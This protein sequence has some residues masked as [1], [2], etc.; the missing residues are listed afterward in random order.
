LREVGFFIAILATVAALVY[1]PHV[2]NG[3]LYY[4]DWSHASDYHDEG[5][6]S[7]ATQLW[8]H[9]IP[10]RP[11][12]AV[13]LPTPYAL[14]GSS[15][16]LHLAM[17]LVLGVAASTCFY[18]F[19]R[20]LSL[21]SVPAGA[22]ALLSLL[23]PWSEAA[24]LWPTASINN[25]AV[26]AYL[27]G[28]VVALR[29]LRLRGKRAVLVHGTAIAMYLVSVLIYEV[30]A[31]AIVFSGLLYRTRTSLTRAA[32]RWL[33]DAVL[34]LSA[35]GISAVYTARVRHVGSLAD[36]VADVPRFSRQGVS[37]LGRSFLPDALDSAP[38][39][40]VVVVAI[41]GLF[42]YAF[43]VSR[44]ATRH[45]LRR[46]LRIAAVGAGAIASAYVMFLGSTIYPL[47][48]GVDTRVN[49]FAGF[50]FASFSY[51]TVVIAA[52]LLPLRGAEALAVVALAGF[53][54][55]LGFV[56]RLRADIGRWDTAR[57]MQDDFLSALE[58][59]LP[60]PTRGS[61]IY[62]FGY[63]AEV[64]PGIPIFTHPWDLNGA[65]RLTYHDPTLFGLPIY[66]RGVVCGEKWVYPAL[67]GAK[68]ASRYMKTI[69]VSVPE[70]KVEPIRSKAECTSASRVF[71]GGPLQ[72]T[73]SRA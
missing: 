54:L 73:P 65:L 64:A 2:V 70:R 9:V 14:F 46:W 36:R 23:F 58:Q 34:V 6:A 40:G 30:A 3:G 67:F 55:G 16:E 8:R 57:V 68:Y 72:T 28:T 38:A 59:T 33:V 50:G 21:S 71:G 47:H 56:D 49:I 10:G 62:S 24:R 13:L 31:C 42:T 20:E 51:A 27:L 4:D 1:G 52:Q 43:L 69:F 12:L 48:S 7:L 66:R 45:A 32:P 39:Q 29:G 61:T 15:A 35:L 37:I 5:W 53:L 11:L 17:A 26:C 60:R 41:A 22:I 19:L 63:P 44:D 18:V 25:L